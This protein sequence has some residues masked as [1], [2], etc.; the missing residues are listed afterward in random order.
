M[1]PADVVLANFPMAGSGGRKW[2]P[3][4]VLSGPL[5][6]VPEYVV[7]YISSVLP[8]DSLPT[9]L[10]MDPKTPEFI[11]TKL[12]ATSVLR[13]H[14]LSTIHG[15]DAVRLLGQLSPSGFQEVQ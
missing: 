3:C 14:K 8:S 12:K 10:V 6:S 2:R 7:A 4:L 1:N 5:G 15:R 13:V 11:S 9:D